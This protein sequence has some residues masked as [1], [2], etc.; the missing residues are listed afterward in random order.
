MCRHRHPNTPE[1]DVSP[2]ESWTQ[3]WATRPKTH[4][5]GSARAHAALVTHPQSEASVWGLELSFWPLEHWCAVWLAS[6]GIIKTNML[7]SVPNALRQAHAKRWLALPADQRAW[8]LDQLSP[9]QHATLVGAL[10]DAQPN[11]PDLPA[12]IAAILQAQ[13]VRSKP[14]QHLSNIG[15]LWKSLVRVVE[16]PTPHPLLCD[17][18]PHLTHDGLAKTLVTR[19][20]G[21]NH[22]VVVEGVLARFPPSPS[23]ALQWARMAIDSPSRTAVRMLLPHLSSNS[24]ELVDL[25]VYASGQ[26]CPDGMAADIFRKVGVGPHTPRV[27]RTMAQ[28][29]ALESTL[30]SK[31]FAYVATHHRADLPDV[32]DEVLRVRPHVM[33]G[34]T[35]PVELMGDSH[36]LAVVEA[37]A[38][39]LSSTQLA[40]VWTRVCQNVSNDD[41]V[42]RQLVVANRLLGLAHRMTDEDVSACMQR[43][44]SVCRSHLEA[45]PA[46]SS[47]LLRHA[48]QHAVSGSAPSMRKM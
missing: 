25:F 26:N 2:T 43:T 5:P 9:Q 21:K 39:K 46:V 19:S 34:Y 18:I 17:I 12:T 37:I 6:I 20:L 38:S 33:M 14:D 48:T 15:S 11:N 41:P 45:H 36:V 3:A 44:P 35:G 1:K 13:Y 22:N 32:L 8:A 23:Q 27:L 10:V 40:T 28:A 24:P 16:Q 7:Q 30:W 4:E 42:V 31:Q 47:Q 29:N